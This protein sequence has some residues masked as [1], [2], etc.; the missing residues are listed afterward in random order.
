LSVRLVSPS[1]VMWAGM[2]R[3]G[4]RLIDGHRSVKGRRSYNPFGGTDLA[5]SWMTAQSF[6]V[7]VPL[8]AMSVYDKL[9][10][11]AKWTA[12]VASI[13]GVAAEIFC[14]PVGG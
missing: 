13:A 5:R 9:P 6:E 14:R 7:G 1:A 12:W 8:L 3:Q 2:D 4:R 11:Y 10:A